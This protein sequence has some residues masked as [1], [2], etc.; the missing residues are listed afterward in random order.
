MKTYQTIRDFERDEHTLRDGQRIRI[1]QY[2]AIFR[3]ETAKTTEELMYGEPIGIGAMVVPDERR[4][5]E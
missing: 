1:E 2:G 4:L 5:R 3:Y